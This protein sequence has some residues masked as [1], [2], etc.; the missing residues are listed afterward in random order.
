MRLTEPIPFIATERRPLIRVDNYC[1][2]GLA[3]P[4]GHQ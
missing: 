1:M 3:L 2:L 4:H